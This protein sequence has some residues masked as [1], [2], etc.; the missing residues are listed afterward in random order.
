MTVDTKNVANRRE[1][2]YESYDDLLAD[3]E[4]LAGQEHKV[5][6]NWTFAQ[7]LEHLGIALEGSLDGI[8]FKAPLA[9]RV[10]AKAFLK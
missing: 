10:F 6:G 8:P 7:I 4:N 1:P 3:A 5:L 2:R 9:M